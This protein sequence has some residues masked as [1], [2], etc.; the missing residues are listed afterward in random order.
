MSRLV[1]FAD[2]AMRRNRAVPSHVYFSFQTMP[3]R[4]GADSV[5]KFCM[6]V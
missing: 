3:F 6:Y 5:V 4:M 2:R 1:G